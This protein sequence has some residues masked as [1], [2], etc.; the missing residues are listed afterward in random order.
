MKASA[1]APVTALL[2]AAVSAQVDNNPVD[3][4]NRAYLVIS[5]AT[6]P[7]TLR[8]YL[9][10][11]MNPIEYAPA[12]LGGTGGTTGVPAGTESW[13]HIFG[14]TNRRSSARQHTGWKLGMATSAASTSFPNTTA[15]VPR[16][17]IWPTKVNGAGPGRIPDFTATPLIQTAQTSYTFSAAGFYNVTAALTTATNFTGDELA[18]S[19]Q[20]KGGEG[21]DLPGT[22]GYWSDYSAGFLT[23]APTAFGYPYGF[24]RSNNTAIQIGTTDFSDP[25]LQYM[26][27]EAVIDQFADWGV[28]GG[29]IVTYPTL[30][31]T[32]SH[33]VNSTLTNVAGYFGYDVAGGASQ[34][35][36]Y[37]LL[38]M[39]IAFA[40]FPGS[41]QLLGQTLELNIADPAI[42]LFG[43]LGYV[44]TLDPQGG[45]KGPK[46]NFPALPALKGQWLGAEA[47]IISST[48]S[49]VNE[50]TQATW[51][52][53]Q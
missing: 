36:A 3:R 46:L 12:V 30:Y 53:F 25:M 40:P 41:F 49:Q 7:T 48:L 39:N 43:D 26:E 14:A 27:G 37:A 17:T 34:S 18:L 20:W 35:G 51:F 47:A 42:G 9:W 52:R 19:L 32:S 1:F 6:H 50:T 5:T 10:S 23:T 4:N 13:R 24:S 31:G 15:Y 8:N 38:L 44:L 33:N 29:N 28:Q 22:Q 2:M 11:P 16:M 45:V 21:D